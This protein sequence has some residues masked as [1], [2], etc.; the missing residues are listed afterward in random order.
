MCSQRLEI[1]DVICVKIKCYSKLKTFALPGLTDTTLRT[2]WSISYGS[3]ANCI[4]QVHARIERNSD[5]IT[6]QRLPEYLPWLSY[7]MDEDNRDPDCS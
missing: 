2:Y 4:I 7:G 6:R 5:R 3:R 1:W